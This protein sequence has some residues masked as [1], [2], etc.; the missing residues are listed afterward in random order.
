MVMGNETAHDEGPRMVIARDFKIRNEACLT[1]IGFNRGAPI[2]F[3]GIRND[4][5][6]GVLEPDGGFEGLQFTIDGEG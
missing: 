4:I 6:L 2:V 1:R 5:A 3:A